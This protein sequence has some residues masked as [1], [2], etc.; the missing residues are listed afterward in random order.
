MTDQVGEIVEQWCHQLLHGTD[1]PVGRRAVPGTSGRWELVLARRFTDGAAAGLRARGLADCPVT[2]STDILG[3]TGDGVNSTPP[4]TMPS[5]NP[6]Y[7]SPTR[8]ATQAHAF[9][10]KARAALI[11]RRDR[12]G[13][14]ERFSRRSRGRCRRHSGE[15]LLSEAL[16]FADDDRLYWRDEINFERRPSSLNP[17]P[18]LHSPARQRTPCAITCTTPP[19]IL[20]PQPIGR[21]FLVVPAACRRPRPTASCCTSTPARLLATA[22]PPRNSAWPLDR[23][24]PGVSSTWVRARDSRHRCGK[25][26]RCAR[27][28]RRHRRRVGGDCPPTSSSATSVTGAVRGG[29][30][31]RRRAGRALRVAQAPVVVANILPVLVDFAARLPDTV[32]P[33]GLLILSGVLRTRGRAAR[34]PAGTASPSPPKS[35]AEWLCVIAKSGKCVTSDA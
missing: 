3:H 25:A 30:F 33:G 32:T 16:L 17:S 34:L 31:A 8:T 1:S 21:R 35:A 4:A 6:R 20:T 28:R 23:H 15:Q 12:R 11:R 14:I 19:K 22:R 5:S 7:M 2:R 24:R 18:D 13:N 9:R 29:R 26:G 10:L 27:P